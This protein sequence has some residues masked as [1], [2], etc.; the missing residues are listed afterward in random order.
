MSSTDV[1]CAGTTQVGDVVAA[2]R[3][4]RGKEGDETGTSA[5]FGMRLA[6]LTSRAVVCAV[7]GFGAKLVQ[8]CICSARVSVLWRGV[9]NLG[10]G[11]AHGDMCCASLGTALACDGIC[12]AVFGTDSA[13][14]GICCASF[15]AK[16]A[17]AGRRGAGVPWTRCR[18]KY[19]AQSSGFMVKVFERVQK[20][21]V[22]GLGFRVWG[23][24][25]RIQGFW[26]G[27]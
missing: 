4:V 13:C 6:V 20:S 3:E 9:S 26:L 5:V 12:C 16:L 14:C 10:L 18:D 8:A 17:H 1:G 27:V 25:V 7:L 22:Q 15:G 11:S 2:V 21:R 23:F 19:A 24:G